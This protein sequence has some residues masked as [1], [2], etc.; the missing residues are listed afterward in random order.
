MAQSPILRLLRFVPSSFHEARQATREGRNSPD[1]EFRPYT[2]LRAVRGMLIIFR[3]TKMIHLAFCRKFLRGFPSKAPSFG[4]GVPHL[5]VPASRCV[6]S[7]RPTSGRR[8]P[9]LLYSGN[10]RA[11]PRGAGR[12]HESRKSDRSRRSRP[13]P[14]TAAHPVRVAA[15]ATA[16]PP[17]A[18]AG[19][20]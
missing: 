6:R 19:W 3:V 7:F 9:Q 12:S 5:R 10:R 2:S 8:R 14:A 17:P 18:T 13:R 16:G 15:T 11:I 1:V 4:D 20:Q